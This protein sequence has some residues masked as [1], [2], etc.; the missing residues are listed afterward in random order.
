[1]SPLL[2]LLFALS[3]VQ[4]DATGQS[5]FPVALPTTWQVPAAQNEPIFLYTEA[6][7]DADPIALAEKLL[8]NYAF[9]LHAEQAPSSIATRR[10]LLRPTS[11]GY[12][13][14]G[15]WL[16]VAWLNDGR[17]LLHGNLTPLVES[18]FALPVLTESGAKQLAV[19]GIGE[20]FL[21]KVT[22]AELAVLPSANQS[23]LVWR[24]QVNAEA[25]SSLLYEMHYA[26]SDGALLQRL[27]L[28][29][30]QTG[31]AVVFL[32][33]PVESLD[34]PQLT[35]Q[36]NSGGAV[37]REAYTEVDLLDLDGSGRMDGLWA[38]TSST[39][40]RSFAGNL[41]FRNSRASK[42]FEEGMGYYHVDTFQRRLQS[43]G[44]VAR[45]TAQKINVEDR[46][47]GFEYANASYNSATQVIAFGTKNVDFAED[48]D[49]ILHEYGHAI[50]DEIQGGLA[51]GFGGS[52]NGGM[53]EGYGD[54][55][56][57]VQA[58]DT[59]MGEWAAIALGTGIGFPAV[60]RLDGLKKYPQDLVGQVH[61]DGELWA[62]ALWEMTHMIGADDSLILVTSAMSLMSPNTNMQQAADLLFVAEQQL[63]AGANAPYL[64]GALTRSEL[65]S[66]PAAEARL[67]ADRRSLLAGEQVRFD[68]G[69]VLDPGADFQVV[70]ST[71][72]QSTVLGPPFQTTLQIGDEL[73]ATSLGLA[74][75]Q[76]T[77]DAQ[78]LANFTIPVP[79]GLPF[80]Q[81]Y[82]FQVMILDGSGAAVK[83]SAPI[84]LRAER[85]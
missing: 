69:S 54:Y 67:L 77:L 80:K 32:P 14:L 15:D 3:P 81:A 31:Q 12:P 4:V 63:T 55:F 22:L 8:P 79:A 76:G 42:A 57:A 6:S 40:N 59:L 70:V 11:N 62:S 35:D 78:G 23:R 45:Q 28:I 37:P 50:H 39:P 34:Q 51:G 20:A 43:L 2:T 52:E 38:T 29:Q 73:L 84:A 17:V 26:A 64:T 48:A 47:F 66:P 71:K 33:N 46:L 9:V 19:D 85:H 58:N 5:Q 65:A 1:M 21:P 27:D 41:D 83:V 25:A 82:F 68:V 72:A 16:R 30:H 75:F 49:V 18:P 44:I 53:G 61:D 60:R 13:V 10:V 56:A 36:N 74:S 7:S 24:V